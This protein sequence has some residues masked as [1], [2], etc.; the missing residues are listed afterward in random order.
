VH[1]GVGWAVGAAV[2]DTVGA[3]VGDTVGAAVGAGV[4]DTVGAGV[5]A[6][7]GAALGAGV[8]STV[9]YAVGYAVGKA[10][11]AG[12]GTATHSV[13]SAAPTVHVAAAHAWHSWNAS[14]SWNLPDG[15]MSHSSLRPTTRLLRPAEQALHA[16]PVLGW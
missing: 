6:A 7:L 12:V 2:G 5:G 8:G 13:A 9:G 4:G 10:V 1:A 11:G 3:G 16:A 15:Q 14:L